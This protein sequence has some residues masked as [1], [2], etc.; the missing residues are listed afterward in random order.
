IV[1][2]YSDDREELGGQL[3][4]E[5]SLCET[6]LCAQI[7]GMLLELDTATIKLLLDNQDLLQEAVE[8]AKNEFIAYINL[9]KEKEELGEEIYERVCEYHDASTAGRLTGMLLELDTVWLRRLLKDP[10]AMRNKIEVA[11]E[12]LTN[13]QS[14]ESS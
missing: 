9:K 1:F 5:V 10:D 11:F 8:K 7:T 12:A 14:E 13:Y 4:L 6:E 2:R 3:F